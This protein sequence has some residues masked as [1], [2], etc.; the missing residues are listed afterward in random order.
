[1]KILRKT[2]AVVVGAVALVATGSAAQAASTIQIYRVY[3]NSPGTDDRGNTSL[4]AEYVMLKNTGPTKHSLKSW[5]LR[6]RSGHVYVFPTFTLGAG[7]YVT[8]HTGRG[9]N[10]SAHLYWGSRAYIWN[11]TGDAAFLRWPGGSLADSCSWGSSGSW[12]YC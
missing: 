2:V 5:T 6:D 7:K 10:T 11:N 9:T 8:V 3:Y 4:N 1:M 12:K